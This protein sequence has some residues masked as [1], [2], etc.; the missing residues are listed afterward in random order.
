MQNASAEDQVFFTSEQ[1]DVLATLFAVKEKH[2]HVDELRKL[3]ESGFPAQ[4]LVDFGIQKYNLAEV[5]AIQG[6]PASVVYL[7]EMY[8][9]MVNNSARV[10]LSVLHDG[11]AIEKLVA[12]GYPVDR[13]IE[14]SP[15]LMDE[16]CDTREIPAASLK[17]MVKHGLKIDAP[18]RLHGEKLL[19][20]NWVA[21]LHRGH[22]VESLL[23][24]GA[25]PQQ[26]D[27]NGRNFL[28]EAVTEGRVMR[29]HTDDGEYSCMGFKK[30]LE[31]A[32][33]RGISLDA[34]DNDG[35]TPLH[36]AGKMGYMNKAAL[37]VSNGASSTIAN[38]KGKSPI[39]LAKAGKRS[40][41]V[42]AIQ[43]AA[44]KRA[45]MHSTFPTKSP[46]P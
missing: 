26:A 27:A 13:L 36:L 42:Q 19:P 15:G 44:A 24:A 17:T 32:V 40:D 4:A 12:N 37:L 16:I 31:I 30:I 45:I 28:H 1:W 6:S 29:A 20:L 14:S 7:Q 21:R 39:Q 22:V 8:P 9:D 5:A 18:A 2:E 25:N 33:A 35:N 10:F 11:A 41:A 46:R 3:I 34:Q 23:D 43:A 38:N